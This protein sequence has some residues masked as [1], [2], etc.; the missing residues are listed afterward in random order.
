MMLSDPSC[1]RC[2]LH[3]TSRSVCIP[4]RGHESPR[5]LFV[6]QAPGQQE[7]NEGRCFVGPAGQLLKQAVKEYDL[8]PSRFTNSVKCFPPEDRDP[9]SEE[10]EAC[11]PYLE[12]EIRHYKPE[13]VVALG[14]I[15]LKNLTGKTGITTWSG[16]VVGEAHGSKVFALMHPSYVLRY[17]QNLHRFE[18][19]CKELAFL[20]RPASKP[21]PPKVEEIGWREASGLL[22]IMEP[23]IAWD[24]ETTGK[25]KHHGGKLRTV[26]FSDGEVSV[27]VNLERRGAPAR[28][29]LREF[30]ASPVHKAAHNLAFEYRW[31]L[32]EFYLEPRYATY[33]TMLMHYLLNENASHALDSV[34]AEVLGAPGWDV[35]PLMKEKGWDY[36]TMPV[37]V[38]G[39]YNAQDAYWTAKLARALWAKLPES[40][41][42]H[43]GRIQLPL[44][45]LCARMEHRGVQID[46]AWA[47]KVDSLYDRLMGRAARRMGKEGSVVRLAKWLKLKKRSLN[48][49][50]D[51]QMRRVF[52]NYLKLPV[53]EK[54]DG[55]EPSVREAALKKVEDKHPL[56]PVYLKWKSMKTLRNNFLGKFPRMAGGDGRVHSSF[57]PA[58]V[59]TGRLSVTNPPMQAVPEDALVRGMVTSRWSSGSVLALDYKQLEI[60]LVASESG[61]EKLIRAIA[62]NED[63]HDLT[64]GLVFGSGFTKRQRSIAKRIN[65][66][67]VYGVSA[68]T[69]AAEFSMTDV[70]AE[71]I[72]NAFR[73]AYP[74]I[75]VW[76]SRQH[77]MVKRD[78]FITSRFGRV[79]RLPDIKGADHWTQERILRQAGNFPIA[80]A[81][82][83]ITNLASV[84]IDRKLRKDGVRSCVVLT[85]HDSVLVDLHPDD[86][87]AVRSACVHVMEAEVQRECPW[88]KVPLAVDAAVT[89]R[90]GGAEI[91]EEPANG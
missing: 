83:D 91:V 84:L 38:V 2:P 61:E 22:K 37:E 33:D 7:E 89:R 27:W 16:G 14:N 50:S 63:L 90:W 13:F 11:R 56:V 64:A 69:L 41:R 43:Y 75:F 25:F 59:V 31:S 9:N 79:R 81:G 67:I 42:H 82:A 10:L 5:V 4:G 6:G 18:A 21:N 26:A 65:F 74:R 36:E 60:R 70:E 47:G 88:L 44:A 17:P 58:F 54:T 24:L 34:A 15:A 66:G 55:G 53:V 80:S 87:D 72:L 57:N 23:P 12:A 85:V 73:R 20:L 52:F 19:H 46:D 8:N 45:K 30:L 86:G 40:L 28:A 48:F 39:P 35:A 77:E 1:S 78:G 3:K 29:M 51:H 71:S 62:D 49:N 32:D 76:M 68:Y